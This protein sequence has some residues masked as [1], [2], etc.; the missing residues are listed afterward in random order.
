M[1]LSGCAS[2]SVVA[3]DPYN[4]CDYPTKPIEKGNHKLNAEYMAKHQEVIGDCRALLGHNETLEKNK[5]LK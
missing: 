3:S 4:Q 1:L 2:Q 5:G